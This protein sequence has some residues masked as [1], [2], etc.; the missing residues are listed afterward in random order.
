MDGHLGS[1]WG[2]APGSWSSVRPVSGSRTYPH[3]LPIASFRSTSISPSLDTLPIHLVI[4]NS[5]YTWH[6]PGYS[7]V[8]QVTNMVNCIVKSAPMTISV[9]SRQIMT[10]RHGPKPL[11]RPNIRVF[12]C[13]DSLTDLTTSHLRNTAAS[14]RRNGQRNA[15]Q[16]TCPESRF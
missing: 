8:R 7:N 3:H 16:N 1:T 2:L 4:L 9:W 11:R 5:K 15:R 13:L 10:L 6:P 14:R 12:P